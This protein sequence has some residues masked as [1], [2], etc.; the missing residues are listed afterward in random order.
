MTEGERSALRRAIIAG[1]TDCPL[2]PEE[3][4][5]FMGR[6][7]SWLRASDVPRTEDALYLKSECLKYIKCRLSHTIL[8][9]ESEPSPASIEKKRVPPRN[10]DRRSGR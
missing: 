5:V 1:G 8:E 7:L 4:A 6:S 9:P 2:T 10:S 3:A